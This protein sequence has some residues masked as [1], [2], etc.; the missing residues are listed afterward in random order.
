MAY[1]RN[2]L[3]Q[4]NNLSYS[5][6]EKIKLL[7]D[8]VK[9]ATNKNDIHNKNIN[10][11]RELETNM[12]SKKTELSH[13]IYREFNLL[14]A[15][16]DYLLKYSGGKG[17]HTSYF[18]ENA[19]YGETARINS[20]FNDKQLDP[21]AMLIYCFAFTTEEEKTEM[22]ENENLRNISYQY[23]CEHVLYDLNTGD[24]YVP[25]E[26]NTWTIGGD[27]EYW[28]PNCMFLVNPIT[29]KL[30]YYFFLGEYT[31]MSGLCDENTGRIYEEEEV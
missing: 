15:K 28:L 24:R 9:E 31:D 1:N 2:S 5:L 3:V 18:I 19:K 20:E 30:Y 23:N 8:Q 27:T 26:N 16:I 25:G 6:Q 14:D 21:R 13:K 29:H 4:W 17:E 11:I 7:E 10:S 12:S 22:I